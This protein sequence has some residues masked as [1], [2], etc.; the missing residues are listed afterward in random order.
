MHAAAAQER[1][2]LGWGGSLNNDFFGDGQDR[3]RSSSYSTSLLFGPE[4]RGALPRDFGDLLEFRLNS[5]II[6]PEDLDVPDPQDRPFAGAYE[7]TL[8]THFRRQGYDLALGGGLSATG[9]QTGQGMYQRELSR[10]LGVPPPSKAVLDAQIGNRFYPALV[11]E[12]MR[13][14]PVAPGVTA[15]P[16]AEA[17]GG[18][19]SLLR[20]GGDFILGS[21]GQGDLLV[22]DG[23]T[24]QVHTVTK[25]GTTAGTSFTLGGDLA[26]IAD[27]FYLPSS[28]GYALTD[29]RLRLRAGV[30]WQGERYGLFYG[31][32]WLGKEFEG[33][34][35]G[36]V[37]GTLNLRIGF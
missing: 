9:E 31:V 12:V 7:L 28:E 24:G 23:T 13:P 30:N 15:R 33:Q 20:V 5:T 37:V 21:W 29:A 25:G 3:W 34:R 35:E 36:Q 1:Q 19:E 14:V 2:F 16:F 32:T 10:A 18:V 11:V 27:S 8:H 22:R 6:T 17:R 4:W 26:W